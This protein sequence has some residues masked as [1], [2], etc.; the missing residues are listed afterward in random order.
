MGAE[1][2][3][4]CRDVVELVTDYLEDRL[5]P[6]QREQAELHVVVCRAC[7]AYLEQMRSTVRLL[8]A[9]GGLDLTPA[10]FGERPEASASVETPEGPAT[11]YKFLGRGRY[12][13]LSGFRWPASG[14]VDAGGPVVLGR[15]GVHA[16]RLRDLPYWVGEELWIMEL[17]GEVVEGPRLVAAGRGHLGSRVA[18]W[19]GPALEDFTRTCGARWPGWGLADPAAGWAAGAGAAY[20]AA[21]A[22]GLATE[23]SGGTYEVG[24]EAER[25]WQAYW[26]AG[27]IGSVLEPATSPGGAR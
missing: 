13:V 9:V 19:D 26:L 17:A 3:P 21:H 15:R 23:A 7:Q 20:V 4:T 27:R 1:R 16:C 22:A 24:A 25:A 5:E 8:G 2:L 18:T 6:A 14:W 10:G 11:F 12:G